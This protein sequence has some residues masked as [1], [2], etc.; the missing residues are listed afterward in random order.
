MPCRYCNYVYIGETG[1]ILQ[2]RLQSM[3][4]AA[5]RNK[6]I[7]NKTENYLTYEHCRDHSRSL[8]V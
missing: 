5:L 8:N 6:K 2:E 4:E 1:K 7:K 3:L